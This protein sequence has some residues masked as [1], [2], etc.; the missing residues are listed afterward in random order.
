MS[1][2]SKKGMKIRNGNSVNFTVVPCRR[3]IEKK[4]HEV[5]LKG[6]IGTLLFA[7]KSQVICFVYQ[8]YFVLPKNRVYLIINCYHTLKKQA[9]EN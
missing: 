5:A 4:E 3:R 1:L 2:R 8:F 9:V 6:T 7:K